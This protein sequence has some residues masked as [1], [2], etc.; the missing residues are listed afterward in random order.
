MTS[1]YPVD[2]S[3]LIEKVR[4]RAIEHGHMPTQ[5]RVMADFKVGRPKATAALAALAESGFTPGTRPERR[6]HAVDAPAP[7]EASRE[8]VPVPAAVTS[9]EEMPAAG[10]ETGV[11]PAQVNTVAGAP[12]GPIPGAEPAPGTY[13][14]TAAEPADTP[15]MIMV[16]PD[17][18][19]STVD[20]P[21]GEVSSAWRVRSW[22]LLLL[23]AGAFVSIWGGWVGLGELTG[24][25]PI[26]LLPG[27]VDNWVINSAITLPIG[28]EAYAAFAL[29]VW[30]APPTNLG[31]GAERARTFARRSAIGALLLGMTGQ[32]AYHLMTAAGIHVAPWPITAFVSALPVVVLGCGAAL[33]HLTTHASTDAPAEREVR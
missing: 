25:G 18:V 11:D 5:R 32:I 27:I 23:A 29:R 9:G 19:S 12:D 30:L 1:A 8:V 14:D 10:R 7:V 6:L 15:R 2:V 26:R 33:A 4:A 24:F 28:V 16:S 21:V 22:P 17:E 3:T 13:P 31:P 20:S